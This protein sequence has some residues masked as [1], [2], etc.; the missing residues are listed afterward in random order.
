MLVAEHAVFL[1]PGSTDMRK[2]INALSQ[3][4]AQTDQCNAFDGSYFVFCNKARQIIK[5]LY[6]EQLTPV[7]QT[8]INLLT[9]KSRRT[10]LRSSSFHAKR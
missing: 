1:M 4:V 7:L 9:L 2:A 6:W 10:A 3:V 8:I 5:I